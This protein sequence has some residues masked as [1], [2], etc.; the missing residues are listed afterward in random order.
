MGEMFC[1]V[2]IP[3]I[4][5]QSLTRAVQSVLDQ[6][7]PKDQFEVIV[8]ND[9]GVLLPEAGWHHLPRV[10]LL[11]TNRVERSLARN[12]GAAVASG[13]YL[14]FLDD[15]DWILPDTLSQYWEVTRNCPAG[16]LYSGY[17]FVDANGNTI[18][19]HIPD[20]NGN[21]F[22]R[23]MSGE[24]QPLQASLFDSNVFHAIGGFLPLGTLRG[25]DEDVDLTRRISIKH[26]IFGTGGLTA[27]IRLDR[28]DSTTKY[29][30]LREQSRQ[31]R[32]LILVQ[33]GVFLRMK[34]SAEGRA[35]R[36]A[37]WNG[38]IAWIY[39]GSILWNIQQRKIFT[40]ISR[41]IFF[42]AS[43]ILSFRYWLLPDF[44]KGV[45]RPHHARGWLSVH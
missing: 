29:S 16:M 30:N 1:S 33:P 38:R 25:G 6:K 37:Y 9:S 19:E 34:H 4:G 35:G 2:I 26:D 14:L 20:E 5:R 42:F 40:S 36:S 32:E 8:V 28:T 41:T 13:K 17:R 22:I 11:N 45:S 7:F 44:W 21:C 15:D 23:F 10:T 43:M 18:A 31:S 24:W 39:L 3:T 27:I 12:C